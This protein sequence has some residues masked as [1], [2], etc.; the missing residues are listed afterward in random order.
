MPSSTLADYAAPHPINRNRSGVIGRAVDRYEGPLKVSGT[1]PYAYEVETP[2]PPVYGVIVDAAIGRGRVTAVDD[3]AARAA[4][5][6]KLV[7]HAFNA[8][9]GMGPK[10]A[11]SHIMSPKVHKPVFAETEVC[12]FGQPVAFVAA[13][14]LE[15]AQEA[16]ELI[17]ISYAEE[18]GEFVFDEAKAKPIP[19]DEVRVGDFEAAFAEAPV[20]V[21]ETYTTPIQNHCQMEPCATT[22]WWEDGALTI[23]ASVQMLKPPQ[24]LLADA[25]GLPNEQVHLLSRYI[26]G[27]FGGK[28][29]MYADMELAAAASRDLGQPVRIALSRQ[30]MFSS[31]V[32]RPATWQRVRLGATPDGRLTSFA[33]Q[34][35]THCARGETFLERAASFSRALYAAPNRLTGHRLQE[36]DIAVA[37]AMRAPGEAT[38][39]MSLE[40][41]MDELAER[42]GLDPIEL[43][44]RNEPTHHPESGLPHSVRQLV[45]CMTDGAKRFGWEKRKPKPLQTLDG[46]WWVGMGMAVAIR[47]NIF[48]PA[49]AAIRV[50]PDGRVILRQGMTDIGTGSYTI[51]AQITAEMMGVPLEQVTVE[52]GDSGFAPAPGSGGQFGAA[53]AG[54]AAFEAGMLMRKTLAGMA[55]RDPGSPIHGA[56]EEEIDFRDGLITASNKSE[57]LASLVSRLAPAGVE[58]VGES[59]PVAETRDYSQHCYGAHF[60][61]LGV[62]AI[63][64][65]VRLRRMLGV[66]ACGRILN[67]KTARSQVT[68]GMIWGV[69]AALSEG[70]AIDPRYGSLINQ[71]LG[72]YLAPVHADIVDLDAYF[73]DEVDDKANPLGIK[74][75]GEVGIC[76][77]GAAVANAIYNACGVRARH[78]PITPDKLLPHLPDVV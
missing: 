40:C 67:A 41:A 73:I 60:V 13:E 9:G 72:S 54:A 65:E 50:E 59:A 18:P 39:M 53:T 76:G 49:K 31:T 2:S 11:R 35:A 25:F 3:S 58:V 23:H 24:H 10:G 51:L 34:A 69:G 77:A 47:G 57:T 52:I 48:L 38:G 14:T 78:Y 43:R 55:A 29:S 16:A 30:Q 75:V 62:N 27:G 5:G 56:A 61:E 6:V 7:W 70:N 36:L 42:V 4:P 66:F 26:G 33:L 21:D 22:A 12:F 19:N 32:H 64:G 28:G 44:L 8:P 68:G 15:Q 63:S 71:D 45:E 37:S 20:Q 46:E 74:G 1:A 17:K